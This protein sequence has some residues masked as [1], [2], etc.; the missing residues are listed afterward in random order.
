MRSGWTTLPPARCVIS[1]MRPSTCA[2]T[3]EIMCFGGVPSRCGQLRRTSSWLPP[4]PPLVT[5]TAPAR[6]SNVPTASR[7]L[8]APRTAAS[9]ARIVPAHTVHGARGH[10]QLVD[11]VPEA[12]VGT[13]DPLQ[14]RL[15]HARPGPPGEVEA[16]DRVAVPDR[17]VAAAL[18]PADV[19]HPLDALRAQPRALLAR[20]EVDVRFRPAPRPG[21]VGPVEA[22]GA[23]PVLPG[24]FVGVLDPKPPLLRTVHHEE[25]A[26]RPVRLPAE[27]GLGL[28]L[29][30]DHALAGLG[31]LGRRHQP[32]QPAAH[33]DHIGVH[34]DM[35]NEAR[36]T[37]PSDPAAAGPRQRS[38][39]LAR[40]TRLGTIPR[41]DGKLLHRHRRQGRARHALSRA[42]GG[43]ARG[44]V[45]DGAAGSGRSRGRRSARDSVRGTHCRRPHARREPPG[46]RARVRRRLG[47]AA[48]RGHPQRGGDA[49]AAR[50][51]D[52]GPRAHARHPRARPARAHEAAA[53][54]PLDLGVLRRHVRAEARHRRPRV[55]EVRVQG[56]D[57]VRA[58]QAHA[59]R[60]REGVGQARPGRLQRASGL[61]RHAGHHRL[62]AAVQ[63]AHAPDPAHAPAGRGHVRVAGRGGRRRPAASGT[64]ARPVRS[65][66]CR[67]RASPKRIAARSGMGW[68]HCPKRL[69]ECPARCP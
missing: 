12:H 39:D 47:R 3:P 66:T 55:P 17:P 16:R 40:A 57:G 26:E 1:T 42:D 20:R 51:D 32:G 4:M 59:G 37:P 14:E 49:A 29:E 60:P 21:V 24:Q 46:R 48:A 52:R 53:R 34:G 18:G 13:A 56:R 8:G 7:L 64:T 30:Q 43:L 15:D 22:G 61:G 69:L 65:I 35:V 25:P 41:L 31:Q 10:A 62:A 36:W 9:G 45:G 33:D 63:D 28:L 23:E 5:I 44:K 38:A 11:P 54:P 68:R 19:R 67:P 2:G 6:S 58:D 27:R 50:R